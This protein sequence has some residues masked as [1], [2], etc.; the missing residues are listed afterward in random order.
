MCHFNSGPFA[1][2]PGT[3]L[4]NESRPS[5]FNAKSQ[6]DIYLTNEKICQGQ[7]FMLHLPLEICRCIHSALSS[8]Y[9]P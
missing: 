9:L 2:G 7:I 6:L 8:I 1:G 3:S 5:L 4:I